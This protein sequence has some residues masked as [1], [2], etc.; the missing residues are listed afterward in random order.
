MVFCR[1][2]ILP[3][4]LLLP[5]IFLIPATVPSHTKYGFITSFYFKFEIQTNIKY[6]IFKELFVDIYYYGFGILRDVVC[7]KLRASVL[8]FL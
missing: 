7:P 8:E 3:Y 6:N 5:E 1:I 4:P 2:E